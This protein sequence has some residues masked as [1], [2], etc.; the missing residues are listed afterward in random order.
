MKRKNKQ[1]F[2]TFHILNFLDEYGIAYKTSGK[3]IGAGW[4]GVE[5][6][7]FCTGGGYHFAVHARHKT[8]NCWICGETCNAVGLV[9]AVLNCGNREAYE[10]ISRFNS[11]DLDWIPEGDE[12][13]QEVIWPDGLV[14]GLSEPAMQYLADRDFPVTELRQQF[15]LKSTK[16]GSSLRVEDRR[17]DFS[18]RILIPVY[19]NRRLQCYLGRDFTGVGE[20]KYMNSPVVASITSPHSCIYNYDTLTGKVIFVEGTTDVWRL[21]AKTGA[22]L[23]ITYTKAQ[24]QSLIGKGITEAT[25]LFDPG[26]EERAEKLSMALTAV[27]DKVRIAYLDGDKDPG[28]MTPDAALKIKYQ[29]IG[30]I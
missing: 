18:S 10:N 1:D 6:C 20:P 8:G 22:F 13:G 23:G 24:I 28:D 3:N 21:G 17:W 16:Y 26:A 4:V 12:T 9:R 15:K 2:E 25:I 7:P 11:E 19:M 5:T 27:I 29:L 30:E 14:N